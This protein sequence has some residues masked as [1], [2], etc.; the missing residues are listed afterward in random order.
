[1]ENG[2]GW[3]SRYSIQILLKNTYLVRQW[4]VLYGLSWILSAVLLKK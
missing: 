4:G 1:M 2:A 3:I